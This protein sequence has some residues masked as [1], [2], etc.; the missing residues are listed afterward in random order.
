MTESDILDVC[1]IGGGFTGLNCALLLGEEDI[2]CEIY[3]TGYGA[4]NLWMGTFD[5]LNY[6]SIYLKESFN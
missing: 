5:F 2:N 3:T 1:I 6:N 4:S